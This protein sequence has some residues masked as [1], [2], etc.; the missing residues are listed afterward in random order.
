MLSRRRDRK[1]ITE[2]MTD[3]MGLKDVQAFDKNN[4]NRL[5]EHYELGH[6]TE[7]L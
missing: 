7:S 3:H 5:R 2:K 6:E 4:H 1:D